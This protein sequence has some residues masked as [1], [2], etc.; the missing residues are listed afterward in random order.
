MSC[1]SESDMPR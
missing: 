1:K